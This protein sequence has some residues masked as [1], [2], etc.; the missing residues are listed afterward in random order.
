MFKIFFKKPNNLLQRTLSPYLHGKRLFK[1][2]RIENLFKRPAQSFRYKSINQ[3]QSRIRTRRRNTKTIQKLFRP[4]SFNIPST[5]SK[6]INSCINGDF[7]DGCSGTGHSS[8]SSLFKVK[9]TP[10]SFLLQLP[11]RHKRDPHR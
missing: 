6:R 8:F 11:M 10:L 3:T 5:P 1:L 4:Y 7:L 9:H 2:I